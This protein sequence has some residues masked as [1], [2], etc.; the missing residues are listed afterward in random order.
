MIAA[1][2]VKLEDL[3]LRERWPSGRR[4]SPA[5]RVY[6][7]R[8]SRVRIPPSPPK[9]SKQRADANFIRVRS[10]FSVGFGSAT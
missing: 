3:F 4:R 8:V 9:F 2:G 7:T 6:L 5:K 10:F 1:L